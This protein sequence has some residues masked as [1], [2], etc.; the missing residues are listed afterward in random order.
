M[1]FDEF[2]GRLAELRRDRSG[3]VAKPYKPVLLAA[4]VLLIHKAKVTSNSVYLDGGLRSAFQQLMERLF[5]DWPRRAN[6]EYPFR[7]LE[8][9]GVW[10]LVPHDGASTE[11]N[12]AKKDHAE[13]WIVLRHVRCAEL[14]EDVYRRLATSFEARFHVLSLLAR[15]YFPSATAGSLFELLGD[16]YAAVDRSAGQVSDRLTERALEE[17]LESHWS[18]TPF[19]EMGVQLS[20]RETTGLP[21]R[22]VLTPVN[23][24]DL[25]GIRPAHREWW[26][27]ELK[28]GRPSDA[29][30]GQASRYVGWM[31][32]EHARDGH[33]AVGA[34]IARQV[35]RK[36]QL[37]VSANP[38]LSLWVFDER[39][40]LRRA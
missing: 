39:F 29:V 20:R 17:H 4:V 28:R 27:F 38:A 3:G 18:E 23:A 36:L 32:R 40:R 37:A 13:A 19:A 31:T 2:C 22:Q 33:S 16:A 1:N 7:H 30:V 26:V 34:I 5:P 10:R 8:N 21:G 14:D 12:A 35:D 9:D 6:P 25:L 24:I 11:L 15:L